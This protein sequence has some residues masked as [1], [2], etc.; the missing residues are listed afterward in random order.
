MIHVTDSVYYTCY[1]VEADLDKLAKQ[2]IRH[3]VRYWVDETVWDAILQ[4]SFET[5]TET[6]AETLSRALDSKSAIIFDNSV[7]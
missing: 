2:K 3:N 5:V 4:P 6:V 1:T 7:K